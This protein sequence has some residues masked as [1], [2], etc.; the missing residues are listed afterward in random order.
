M[1]LL[2]KAE[3]LAGGLTQIDLRKLEL[4]RAIAAQPKLLIAD[5]SM[6]G[7]A[8]SETDE[9]LA[10]LLQLNSQGI[11]VIMIEHI[12]RAVSAFFAAPGGAGCRKENCRRSNARGIA[13]P[14]GGKDLPWRL[15][16]ISRTCMQATVRSRC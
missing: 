15:K 9:I 7:L 11:A 1:G 5:E 10:L 12:M 3:L 16:F 8:T 2:A 14:L 6:A 4:A 13:R